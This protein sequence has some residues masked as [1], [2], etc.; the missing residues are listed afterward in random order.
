VKGKISRALNTA[1][2]LGCGYSERWWA[3]NVAQLVECFLACPKAWV[4][5]LA[6]PHEWGVVMHAYKLR[7]WKTE[8]GDSRIQGH[9]QL[10]RKF[11]A[12][13]GYMRHCLKKKIRI[14]WGWGEMAQWLRDS[15]CSSTR[16]RFNSQ[17]THGG[18]QASIT[19]VPGDLMHFFWS[20][21]LPAHDVQVHTCRQNPTYI[22]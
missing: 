19:P 2:T 22:K 18:S 21:A 14:S 6:P 1:K 20:W 16:P 12:S 17:Q 3:R 15:G 7:I 10:Y 13:L 4:Q 9:P 8:A 11:E 5:S